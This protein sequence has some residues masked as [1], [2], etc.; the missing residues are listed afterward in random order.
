[1]KMNYGIINCIM[2]TQF[3]A[4]A[5]NKLAC[6]ITHKKKTLEWVLLLRRYESMQ[7]NKKN[8]L[9]VRVAWNVVEAVWKPSRSY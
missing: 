9:R 2:T 1:M 8:T 7:I 5:E 6:F 4:T 3:G